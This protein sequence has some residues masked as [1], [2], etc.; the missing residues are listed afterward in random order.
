MKEQTCKPGACY[1]HARGKQDVQ[2][3]YAN[4][5]QQARQ[6]QT[7]SKPGV[8]IAWARDGFGIATEQNLSRCPPSKTQAQ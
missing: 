4:S 2:Q 1:E 7:R 6:Q 8:H 5:K 3:E